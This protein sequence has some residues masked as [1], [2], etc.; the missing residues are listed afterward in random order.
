MGVLKTRKNKKFSYS[1][2]YY[3]GEGSPYK[4]ESKFDKYRKATLETKGLKAKFNT[5][6]EDYKYNKDE[7]ARKTTLL[8]AA[9]LVFVFLYIIDFDLS[10]FFPA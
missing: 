8:I 7:R 1:P 10:I 2:R 6:W 4:L 5:A 3:E 9:V